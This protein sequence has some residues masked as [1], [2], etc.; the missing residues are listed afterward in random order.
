MRIATIGW[1]SLIWCPGSLRVQ[2]RWRSYEPELPIEFARISARERVTLVVL[3]HV[4]P[5]RTFWPVSESFDLDDAIQNLR[6][7]EGCGLRHVHWLTHDTEAEG[8]DPAIATLV[9]GWLRTHDASDAAIW[10]GLPSNWCEKRKQDLSPAGVVAYLQELIGKGQAKAAEE[11]V[12]NTPASIRT[13]VRARI[14]EE[15]GWLPSP[16]DPSLFE[17]PE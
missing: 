17:V 12:R 14:E 1:G 16:L 15:L 7:R 9:R 8:I 5:Q 2:S 10:T 11:Y 13:R 6:H 4:E 3:S